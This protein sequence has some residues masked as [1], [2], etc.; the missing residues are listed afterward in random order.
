M[1]HYNDDEQKP[2]HFDIGKKMGEEDQK[3][4]DEKNGE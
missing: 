1:Y 3:D 4:E 2:N